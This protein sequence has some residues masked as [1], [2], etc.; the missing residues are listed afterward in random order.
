[1]TRAAPGRG[2]GPF[3]ITGLCVPLTCSL[4]PHQHWEHLLLLSPGDTP[5]DSG[6]GVSDEPQSGVEWGTEASWDEGPSPGPQC[7]QLTSGVCA[8]PHGAPLSPL[9]ALQRGCREQGTLTLN[10]LPLLRGGTWDMADTTLWGWGLGQG[11]VGTWSASS[12]G[13][14]HSRQ[15][16]E[17]Y[18]S[19]SGLTNLSPGA[20]APVRPL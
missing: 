19:H 13:L 18:R 7:S 20:V 10:L 8:V 6:E 3:A 12:F 16:G 5:R 15:Q 2:A 17:G 1:M 9:E 4:W 14:G 11:R